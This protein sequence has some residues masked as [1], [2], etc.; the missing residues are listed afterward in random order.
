MTP[1]LQAQQWFLA[2]QKES[3]ST[4][5][6]TVLQFEASAVILTD[7]MEHVLEWKERNDLMVWISGSEWIGDKNGW[8]Q[9]AA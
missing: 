4:E 5:E 7:Q 2:L 8:E 9:M 6:N 3:D 1:Q